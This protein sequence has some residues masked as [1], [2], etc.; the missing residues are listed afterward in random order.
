[1]KEIKLI[2]VNPEA[3]FSD[4]YADILVSERVDITLEKILKELGEV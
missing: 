2:V 3:H 4:K 1:M